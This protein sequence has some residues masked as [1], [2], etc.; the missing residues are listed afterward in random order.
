VYQPLLDTLAPQS[1]T[2][3]VLMG[4]GSRAKIA[5][6]LLARGWSGSTPAAVVVS[7]ATPSAETWIGTLDELA[8]GQALAHAQPGEVPGTV[9]IGEVVSLAYQLG[10]VS[11]SESESDSELYPENYHVRS[12]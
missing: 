7:V 1:T 6:R 12:R 2:V 8:S 10:A 11:R 3:V 4:L 9:V 5:A